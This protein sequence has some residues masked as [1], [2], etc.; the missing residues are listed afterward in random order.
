[1]TIFFFREDNFF[2]NNYLNKINN[3]KE[4]TG[5]LEIEVKDVVYTHYQLINNYDYVLLTGFNNKYL[6]KEFYNQVI[7][8]ILFFFT[9][10]ILF[11]LI[12]YLL[13][14]LQ[15][16]NTSKSNLI[17]ATSHDLNNYLYSIS[18]IAKL[19]IKEKKLVKIILLC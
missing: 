3:F 14:S 12:L 17:R 16:S 7:N 11:L 10:A 5:D 18:G 8:V 6:A 9:I 4:S 1:M 15:I 2:K 19:L 13:R